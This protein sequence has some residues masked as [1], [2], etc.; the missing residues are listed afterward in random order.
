MK[1][2][3]IVLLILLI[4]VC[5]ASFVYMKLIDN[6]NDSLLSGSEIGFSTTTDIS[7]DDSTSSWK[8]FV[9][10][11]DGY[12]V[13]YPG[14][15]VSG[16]PVIG[17]MNDYLKKYGFL[18]SL[19]FEIYGG[20]A[21]VYIYDGQID[22]AIN[23]YKK[24]DEGNRVYKDILDVKIGG[25]D[26][27]ILVWTN[28]LDPKQSD[29]KSHFVQD[30]NRPDVTLYLDGSD[31][32]VNSIRFIDFKKYSLEAEYLGDDTYATPKYRVYV[33]NNVDN[34]KRF[35]GE[36]RMDC[37]NRMDNDL[38][39]EVNYEVSRLGCWWGGAG[40]LFIIDYNDNKFLVRSKDLDSQS[41]DGD[42]VTLF[43]LE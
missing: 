36:Y 25:S 37:Q 13:K 35:V 38:S 41:G 18:E 1:I 32:F 4:V 17:L 22:E 29:N 6:Q 39:N 43:D 12:S 28:K 5:V 10:E 14:E 15:D 16:K 7:T 40:K 31:E 24:I 8:T 2:K 42:F 9:N 33:K 3:Y 11:R 34:Q 21:S 19:N 27:K 26:G 30:V 20:W 23:A